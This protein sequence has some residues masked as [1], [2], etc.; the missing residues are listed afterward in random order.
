[1]STLIILRGISGSGKSTR[2][3]ELLN[4]TP[5]SVIISR[6]AIR[7]ML[8]GTAAAHGVDEKLVTLVQDA[9]V[10]AA[11]QQGKTI[12]L[13]NTNV[14]PKFL[15]TAIY[16]VSSWGYEI[17]VEVI[18]TPLDEALRRN[19]ARDRVVPEEVVRKQHE[20]LQQTKEWKT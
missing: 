9:S 12:I 13:D 5:N 4:S 6:D 10:N 17:V 11:C 15:D 14:V 7:A 8:W 1:M 16:H 19:A 18:D 20:Q 3:L 2:A